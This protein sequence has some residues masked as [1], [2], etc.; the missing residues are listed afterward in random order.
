[1]IKKR[2]LADAGKVYDTVMEIGRLGTA[3]PPWGHLT[4]EEKQDIKSF[5]FA[6]QEK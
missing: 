6:M 3:M 4:I 2:Y 1:M 5:I